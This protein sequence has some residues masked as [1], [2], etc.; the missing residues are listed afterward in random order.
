MRT[1]M[2]E[3]ALMACV[4]LLAGYLGVE[5]SSGALRNRERLAA[6]ERGELSPA[7]ATAADAAL[8][9]RAARVRTAS[10]ANESAAANESLRRRIVDIEERVP[11][12]RSQASAALGRLRAAAVAAEADLLPEV[13]RVEEAAR[14]LALTDAGTARSEEVDQAVR[15][16]NT[17]QRQRMFRAFLPNLVQQTFKD[18]KTKLEL[19]ASQEPRIK[20]V[21]EAFFL[22]LSKLYSTAFEGQFRSEEEN[23]KL[24]RELE[25]RYEGQLR[26]ILTEEQ[27]QKYVAD[28]ASRKSRARLP[29]SGRK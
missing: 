2:P 13:D 27:F 25:D 20:E 14:A 12:L 5:A 11:A 19:D 22:D 3:A 10:A 29:G 7:Q 8:G 23:Q 28:K 4:L 24:W 18:L 1:W 15:E 21:L 16:V 17:E 26:P 6:L 9:S